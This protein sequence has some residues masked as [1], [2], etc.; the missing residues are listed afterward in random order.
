[1]KF[2]V[3]VLSWEVS[4]SPIE[5]EAGYIVLA[6]LCLFMDETGDEIED[7][8]LCFGATAGLSGPR[9][10]FFFSGTNVLSG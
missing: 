9:V 5:V 2:G 8:L 10:L 3:A 4:F 7:G 1:M 6:G